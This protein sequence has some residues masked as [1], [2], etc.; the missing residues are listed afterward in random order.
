MPTLVRRASSRPASRWRHPASGGV[1]GRP[2]V[3]GMVLAAFHSALPIPRAMPTALTSSPRRHAGHPPALREP[4]RHGWRRPA[5][6]VLA[7]FTH[8]WRARL[9]LAVMSVDLVAVLFGGAVA[10]LPIARDIRSAPRGWGIPSTRA[11]VG[12]ATGGLLIARFGVAL[13]ARLFLGAVGGFGPD[14]RRLRALHVL[15]PVAGGAGAAG[16]STT[17]AW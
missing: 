5:G 17:S 16:G 3:A 9:L 11:P 15:P 14:D 4:A 10:L 7:G 13:D 6:R 12:A 1:D 8:V 2:A